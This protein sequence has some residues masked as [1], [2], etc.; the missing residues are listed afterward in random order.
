MIIDK[1]YFVFERIL[2]SLGPVSTNLKCVM[3]AFFKNEF[4]TSIKK[5]R[6][7]QNIPKKV[8]FLFYFGL[9]NMLENMLSPNIWDCPLNPTVSMNSIYDLED[10]FSDKCLL[11]CI[12]RPCLLPE[13]FV[14]PCTW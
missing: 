5:W 1:F 3:D 11:L 7:D 12:N 4:T 9:E 10:S 13:M 14:L 6:D 8:T 2:L